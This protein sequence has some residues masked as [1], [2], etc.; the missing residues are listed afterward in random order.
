MYYIHAVGKNAFGNIG[1]G[2]KEFGFF[3]LCVPY[4]EILVNSMHSDDD[5]IALK[6]KITYPSCT[7]Q[8]RSVSPDWF[9]LGQD[10]DKSVDTFSDLLYIPINSLK[11]GT[12]DVI[13]R[14]TVRN[15]YN[16]D[17]KLSEQISLQ[18]ES[19]NPDIK[20]VG[21][22]RTVGKADILKL[23][24]EL[25]SKKTSVTY[26]WNCWDSDMIPCVQSAKDIVFPPLNYLQLELNPTDLL[27]TLQ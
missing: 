26:K 10:F 3:V 15:K 22:N 2:K 27:P 16:S 4:V 25:S 1:T 12:Y 21:G 19:L 23:Y 24:T 17:E 9:V 7:S 11:A 14:Y 5:S 13:F 6:A 8:D 18:I 20:I